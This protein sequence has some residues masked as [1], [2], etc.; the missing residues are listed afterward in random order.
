MPHTSDLVFWERELR[1]SSN[2]QA[3]HPNLW[4]L[5][6]EFGLKV[7]QRLKHASL[8]GHTD[9][10]LASQTSCSNGSHTISSLSYLSPPFYN[11]HELEAYL[12]EHVVDL[13]HRHLFDQQLPNAEFDSLASA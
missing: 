8:T 9:L 1:P 5:H 7:I 12:A 3:R 11:L 2:W 6:N 4:Q 10:V 13:L